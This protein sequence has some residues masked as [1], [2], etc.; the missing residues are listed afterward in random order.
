MNG[1]R[2][3]ASAA[4]P[5][6]TRGLLAVWI[7]RL[8]VPI[9]LAWLVIIAVLNTTVPQLEVVGQEQSVSMSSED[10]PSMV[11]MK[12][13]GSVFD[14]FSSDSSAMIV[15]EGGIRSSVRMLAAS[16]VRSSTSSRRTPNMS[17]MCRTSGGATR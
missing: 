10:A 4:P 1:T 13:I 6:D 12:R 7:R 11:A 9:I 15:L 8:S 2:T 16:T 3:D 5:Q 17:S 14:E